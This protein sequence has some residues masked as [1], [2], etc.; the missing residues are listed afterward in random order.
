MTD[1]ELPLTW[2]AWKKSLAAAFGT[3]EFLG[4]SEARI[5]DLAYHLGNFLASKV[6]PG[7][8]EHR[9]LKELW[10][11]GTEQER[12]ALTGMLVKMLEREKAPRQY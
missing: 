8:P 10:D 3:A 6:E 12:Q 1:M 9:L 5:K 7:T 4:L 2:D 11:A